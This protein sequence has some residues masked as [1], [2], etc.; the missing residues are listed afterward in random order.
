MTV[1]RNRPP[2]RVERSGANQASLPA[3]LEAEI[4]ML[5]GLMRQVDAAARGDKPLSELL[6]VLDMIGKSGTR[7]ATLLKAQRDL[8][9]SPDIA[10]AINDA[11]AEVIRDLGEEP[12]P[13]GKPAAQRNPVVPP[14]PR[15][16]PAG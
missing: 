6:H 12:Y 8:A 1:R 14:A 7:L 5:R 15:A 3:D 13:A 4:E 11:L 9:E 10:T 2:R 16:D